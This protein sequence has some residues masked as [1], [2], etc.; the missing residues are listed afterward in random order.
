MTIKTVPFAL[1]EYLTPEEIAHEHGRAAECAA[2]VAWLRNV[3]ATD[4]SSEWA[5][6]WAADAIEKGEHL[7]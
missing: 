1:S 3:R 7:A 4:D 6:G 5:F 2:I